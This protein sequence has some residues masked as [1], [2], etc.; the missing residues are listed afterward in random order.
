MY[1]DVFGG[2]W[3]WKVYQH[4]SVYLGSYERLDGCGICQSAFNG[5]YTKWEFLRNINE[6]LVSENA[7]VNDS[8]VGANQTQNQ[9]YR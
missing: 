1:C 2:L 9:S 7:V 8:L 6:S 5:K 3:S 4:V